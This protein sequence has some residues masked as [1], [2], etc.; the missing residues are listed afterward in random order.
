MPVYH[1]QHAAE[2][3]QAL[4]EVC[5][6]ISDMFRNIAGLYQK[7]HSRN[8]EHL[9]DTG[10][11]S[12]LYSAEQLLR[13][14]LELLKIC[15]RNGRPG[16]R[17]LGHCNIAAFPLR[18]L[19]CLLGD[20]EHIALRVVAMRPFEGL[21]KHKLSHLRH[22]IILPYNMQSCFFCLHRLCFALCICNYILGSF[23][24]YL[25][26]VVFLTLVCIERMFQ[27]L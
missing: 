4:H 18:I 15:I 7:F 23:G 5:G 24:I 14:L 13:I 3:I 11:S 12:S 17:V 2:L 21:R 27:R 9:A 8:V 1:E 10:F 19:L 25:N 20:V 6:I 16:V 26:P 22:N